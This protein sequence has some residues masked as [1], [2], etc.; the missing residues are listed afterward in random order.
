MGG[1]AIAQMQP[2]EIIGQRL[3]ASSSFLTGNLRF[4]PRFT[5]IYVTT[6]HGGPR[7]IKKRERKEG[8]KNEKN[9][10]IYIFSCRLF[11]Y[12]LSFNP[13][14]HLSS[15]PPHPP[16][17]WPCSPPAEP[18]L[19]PAGHCLAHHSPPHVLLRMPAP[20]PPARRGLRNLVP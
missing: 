3:D 11:I 2:S 20:C 6:I 17:H 5:H 12:F 16:P 8:R 14:V 18:S 19:L 1:F 4:K 13:T 7:K 9:I 15:F 10:Y